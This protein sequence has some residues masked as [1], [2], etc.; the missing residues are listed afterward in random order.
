MGVAVTLLRTRTGDR[1]AASL[2][3]CGERR[4][5]DD[6]APADGRRF[7]GLI[8]EVTARRVS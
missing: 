5:N 4:R 6:G 7:G 2:Q 1:D 8:D 3:A